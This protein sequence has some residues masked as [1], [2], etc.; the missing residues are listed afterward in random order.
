MTELYITIAL[1]IGLAM[2]LWIGRTSRKERDQRIIELE[3]ACNSNNETINRL[4]RENERL[5]KK[6]KKL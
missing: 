6:E 1:L 4:R 5:K 3:N 2:G